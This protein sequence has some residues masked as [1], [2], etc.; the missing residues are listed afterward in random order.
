MLKVLFSPTFFSISGFPK[1]EKC[2]Y[3]FSRLWFLLSA[4]FPDFR[5]LSHLA[6]MVLMILVNPGSVPKV[7]RGDDWV[8]PEFNADD[9]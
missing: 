2:V 6:L 7:V 9:V 1:I 3:I 4:T 8:G 5:L